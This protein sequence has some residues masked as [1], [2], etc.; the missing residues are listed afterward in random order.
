MLAR[1]AAPLLIALCATPGLVAQAAT[2][3]AAPFESAEEVARP[4]PSRPV[5][6]FVTAHPDDEDNALGALLRFNY[7]VRVVLWTMTRGEG[8]QNEIGLEQGDA[9]KL[10]RDAELEAAHRYDGFEQFYPAR[11]GLRVEVAEY[12]DFGF[13]FSVGETL[14]KWTP[15]RP[16]RGVCRAVLQAVRPHVVVTMSPDGDGGGQHHQTSAQLMIEECGLERNPWR[17]DGLAVDGAP[18]H[19]PLKVYCA[20]PS[21]WTPPGA[22]RPA[23]RPASGPTATRPVVAVDVDADILE[24]GGPRRTARAL[25]A[26]ARSM[27]KS[28]GMS[29]TLEPI[30][31]P[32][33][34]YRLLLDRTAPRETAAQSAG[35]AARSPDRFDAPLFA[36]T[37][38]TL[39]LG[40]SPVIT[41]SDAAET[42]RITAFAD[43]DRVVAGE[44]LN[45]AVE[46]VTPVDD[47]GSTQV[48]RAVL[49]ATADGIPLVLAESRP[50]RA[51]DRTKRFSLR[52]EIPAAV[53]DAARSAEPFFLDV[54][55]ERDG[56][57]A[58]VRVR[59]LRRSPG[60]VLAGEQRDPVVVV[61]P[62]DVRVEPRLLVVPRTGA[63]RKEPRPIRVHV[64]RN[65]RTPCG[66]IV[67]L[68]GEGWRVELDAPTFAPLSFDEEFVATGKVYVLTETPG[69]LVPTMT[70]LPAAGGT[71]TRP[72]DALTW[73]R[74]IDYPHVERRLQTLPAAGAV[75]ILDLEPPPPVRVGYVRG[76]GEDSERYLAALGAEVVALS[77]EDLAYGDLARFDVLVIGA[78]AY[79]FRPE[80]IAH[81]RRILAFVEGGGTVVCQYQKTGLD[82]P[83]F[84]PYAA[85]IGAARVTDEHGPTTVLVPDHPVFSTP[86]RLGPADWEGWVRDRS[87][88]HLDLAGSAPGRFREL[89]SVADTFGSNAGVRPGAF[90][91][92]RAG[93][94]RWIYCALA[95]WRQLPEGVPGAWRLWANLLALRGD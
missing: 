94:G 95:L 31:P 46:V 4:D 25:A 5:A 63:A 60:D 19:R 85:K 48:V 78:R 54:E 72:V 64:R 68:G 21:N 30:G 79:E 3:P 61:P 23:Q 13:S 49:S 22:S 11:R 53:D 40:P 44:D 27:H 12:P 45:V 9:L 32:T 20:D 86:N 90:V 62:W 73:R 33:R 74:T 39:G 29:R 50:T 88:Y 14:S 77:A 35:T 43:R 1:R 55:T 41:D 92:A 91:E 16:G 37:R 2:T 58:A 28:Q 56:R 42:V 75:R 81:R 15:E 87:L 47:G 8:G 59:V 10:L 36:G 65:A 83:D 7:G 38:E 71:A 24:R 17:A 89:L 51:N 57:R 26:E 69:P 52:A 82:A 84:A 76:M 70:E 67:G 93:R 34:R 18:W 66:G 80:L 6:L